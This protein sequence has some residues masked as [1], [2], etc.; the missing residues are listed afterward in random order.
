MEFI[1]VDYIMQVKER[2]MPF[3]YF[4]FIPCIWWWYHFCI[5]VIKSI[6]ELFFTIEYESVVD[7]KPVRKRDDY[8]G[9]YLD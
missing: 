6:L 5:R 8:D 1:T 3:I 2:A 9:D 7:E 4:V